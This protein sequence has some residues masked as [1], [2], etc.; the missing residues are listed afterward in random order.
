[1]ALIA[2]AVY[3]TKANN[4]N[5]FTVQTLRS[6]EGSVNWNK[7]RL[8]VIDNGSCV[9]TKSILTKHSGW[10]F[11][12]ETITLPEN[13]GTARAINKAW[14]VRNPGEHCIKMDNDVVIHQAGWLDTLEECIARDPTIGIIGLK[15]KDLFEDPYLVEVAH[16]IQA[17]KM[18]KEDG[19][20][21]IED[22][23]KWWLDEDTN[24]KPLDCLNF[25]LA[26]PATSKALPHKRGE[27][28]LNVEVV[29]HVMGT[30]QLYNS[31]LLDKIGYLYQM[32]ELYG[33]DDSLAAARS[34]R[35]GFYNCFYPHIDM[36]HIDPGDNPYT[37][38]KAKDSGVYLEK[39]L[40]LREDISAGR[41]PIYYGPEDA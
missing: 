10:Y 22:K 16:A 25:G 34:L 13:I 24:R 17:E 32:G 19:L 3:D 36:D 26:W 23:Y 20:K 7:H 21:I 39:F 14:R 6:L 1:M 37:Q 5:G 41:V 38:Q 2:M 28:W 18:S 11:P 33:F 35:A 12:F 27:K 9:H 8:I 30:C 40:R 29:N 15:R 31:A 4:R